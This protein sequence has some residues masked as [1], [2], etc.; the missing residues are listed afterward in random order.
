MELQNFGMTE[1]HGK[2]NIAPL[3]Q[4]RAFITSTSFFP[5]HV[6]KTSTRQQISTGLGHSDGVTHLA[7]L[8][9]SVKTVNDTTYKGKEGMLDKK[10]LMPV[11]VYSQI[12][13]V[14]MRNRYTC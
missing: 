8:H 11:C 12:L 1:G 4:S 5:N 10:R 6:P 2:P 3:F 14:S 13:V 9:V 7:F